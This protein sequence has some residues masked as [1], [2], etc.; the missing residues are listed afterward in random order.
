MDTVEL[1]Y[2]ATGGIV[3][4][5][6]EHADRYVATGKYDKVGGQY[7]RTE[8]KEPEA[9]P[10]STPKA[11]EAPVIEPEAIEDPILAVAV[12]RAAVPKA[13]EPPVVEPEPPV[14]EPETPEVIIEDP[15]LAVEEVD[16]VKLLTEDPPPTPGVHRRRPTNR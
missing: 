7:A 5:A 16:F 14:V 2:L 13:P 11:P 9:P 10:V 1:R 15:I 3:A 6:A 4:V 12:A 8:E